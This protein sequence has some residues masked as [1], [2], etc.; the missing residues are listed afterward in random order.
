MKKTPPAGEVNQQLVKERVVK[1]WN[2]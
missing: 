2:V 1:T